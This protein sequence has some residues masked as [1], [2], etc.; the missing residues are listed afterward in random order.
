MSPDVSSLIKKVYSD[1]VYLHD[2]SFIDN[3]PFPAH[4][5]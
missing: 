4:L 3:L 2:R 1:K 5:A